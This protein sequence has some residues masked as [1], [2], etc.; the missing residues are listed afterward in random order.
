MVNLI[1]NLA[2]LTVR[3][4][5]DT[6]RPALIYNEAVK[7]I[8]WKEFE[9]IELCVG[10]IVR[11]ENFPEARSPAYKLWVDFGPHGV[12]QSSAQITELY[13]KSDLLN[14]QV[15]GVLNLKPKFIA[16]FESQ[17]LI[18]GFEREPGVVVLAGPERQ[19]PDGSKLF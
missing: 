15:V 8:E 12:K 5:G 18:T 3:T 13:A 16:G 6:L 17:V 4:C 7:P 14:R 19:V 10:T 2:K 11:V 1:P 9:A